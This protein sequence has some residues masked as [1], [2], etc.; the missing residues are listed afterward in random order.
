MSV[1][2]YDLLDVDE[3]ADAGEIR[4]RLCPWC[5]EQR[6]GIEEI[7]AEVLAQIHAHLTPTSR[8]RSATPTRGGATRTRGPCI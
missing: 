7:P 8:C 4:D 6:L 3:S 1:S 5:H 2:Y